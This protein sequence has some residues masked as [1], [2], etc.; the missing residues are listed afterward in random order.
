M[1]DKIE[2]HVKGKYVG[3]AWFDLKGQVLVHV[4]YCLP[5]QSLFLTPVGCVHQKICLSPNLHFCEC[6]LIC[7]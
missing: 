2:V 3:P 6:E 7:K 5:D 4:L 1:D